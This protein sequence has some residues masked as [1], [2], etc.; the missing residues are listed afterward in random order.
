MFSRIILFSIGLIAAVAL[1]AGCG[2]DAGDATDRAIVAG[3]YPLAF[4][5]EQLAAAGNDVQNLTPA[6]A[7]PHDL[8]L[9]ARDVVAIPDVLAD[10]ERLKAYDVISPCWTMGALSKEQSA[11]LLAA[12][13]RVAELEALVGEFQKDQSRIEEGILEALRK[14]DSF[15]DA[16]H[17][18][19]TLAAD[20]PAA[21]ISPRFSISA[22]QESK[23]S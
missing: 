17:A 1:L 11:G 3:F 23:R 21:G 9:S 15:E 18:A 22:G 8:E 5:A 6:G 20:A 7:E 10:P 16:V 12:E 19:G 2:A 4:A 13:P 14:L